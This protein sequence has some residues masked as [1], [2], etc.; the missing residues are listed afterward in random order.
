ML[1]VNTGLLLCP[2]S[3]L[4]TGIIWCKNPTTCTHELH[5]T[6]R[7]IVR[8]SQHRL[9]DLILGGRVFV[10]QSPGQRALELH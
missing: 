3:V 7:A 9:T 1:P 10:L 2:Q 6:P 4:H 8:K 5:F